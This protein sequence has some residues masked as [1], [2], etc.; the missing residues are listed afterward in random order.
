MKIVFLDRATIGPTVNIA[1]PAAEHD[2]QEYDRTSAAQVA[3]RIADADIVITNKAPVRAEQLAAAPK[4]KM[5]SVAATGYDVIDIDA[6]KSS[7]VTV[8]NV[9]GYAEN[10]VPE[11]TFSLILALRRGLIG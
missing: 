8:S 2:W 5:I 4:L 11:H 1:R 10:T 3:E 6:C 7:G 9:R